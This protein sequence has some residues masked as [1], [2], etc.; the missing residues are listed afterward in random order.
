MASC[1]QGNIYLSEAEGKTWEHYR[2]ENTYV[3]S[4]QIP[5][6]ASWTRTHPGWILYDYGYCNWVGEPPERI[7]QE[8]VTASEPVAM[9]NPIAMDLPD[10]VRPVGE[11]MQSGGFGVLVLLAAVAAGGWY[12]VQR[13]RAPDPA[14]HPHTDLDTALPV[15]GIPIAA[16]ESPE[17]L[18]IEEG[19][20]IPPGYELVT[21]L[22]DEGEDTGT[23]PK[24]EPSPWLPEPLKQQI[25]AEVRAQSTKLFLQGMDTADRIRTSMP[26]EPLGK[27]AGNGL[28]FPG[29]RPGNPLEMPGKEGETQRNFRIL[30]NGEAEAINHRQA[31]DACFQYLR[32]GE[33]S[34]KNLVEAVFGVASGRNYTPLS[35]LIRA[36]KTEWEEIGDG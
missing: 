8:P 28:E 18:D 2:L 25:D 12:W 32:Q 29:N 22:E 21:E 13:R 26:L 27:Q 6:R 24:F 16:H 11:G 30:S 4:N 31:R 10:S 20:P 5:N 15:L 23:S 33:T 19:E 14:Y 9:V 1:E 34:L 7:I 17:Y 35:Q 36:W 3:F